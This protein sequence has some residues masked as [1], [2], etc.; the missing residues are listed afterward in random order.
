MR[1]GLGA[2]E[3][4]F[5]MT[6]FFSGAPLLICRTLSGKIL[7]CCCRSACHYRVHFLYFPVN[8]LSYPVMP[9]PSESED[10]VND[11]KSSQEHDAEN[12]TL[13]RS[14]TLARRR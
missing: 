13:K 10:D 12:H 14:T 2:E 9:N 3:D 1:W 6:R 5:F 11:R 4:I 7:I 8:V